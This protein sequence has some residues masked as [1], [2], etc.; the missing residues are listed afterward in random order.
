[1]PGD[2]S[3]SARL[4][5]TLIIAHAIHRTRL[6]KVVI[7]TTLFLLARLKERFPA[8][9]GSSGHRLFISAFMIASKVICDD[10]YSNESWCIVGPNLY[11]LKGVNQMEHEMCSYLQWLLHIEAPKLDAFT[12]DLS[13]GL[14][15]QSSAAGCLLMRAAG[16]LVRGHLHSF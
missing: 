6:P 13:V 9:R 4:S 7:F 10:T 14:L 16:T 8:T 5:P 1:M 2:G 3:T 15:A 12:Q 11:T